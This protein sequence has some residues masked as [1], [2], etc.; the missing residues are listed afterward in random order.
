[1]SRLRWDLSEYIGVVRGH[2]GEFVSET[3]AAAH[4]QCVELLRDFFRHGEED[5]SGI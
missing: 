1:M 2:P 3:M 4:N 5:D